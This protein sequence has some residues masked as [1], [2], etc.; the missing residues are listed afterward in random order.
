[1]VLRLQYYDLIAQVIIKQPVVETKLRT[2]G[3]V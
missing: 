2:V 1:M 3:S